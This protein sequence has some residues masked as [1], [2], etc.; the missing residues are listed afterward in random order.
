MPS[1]EIS[2]DEEASPAEVEAVAAVFAEAGFNGP[3]SAN[4]GRRSLGDL[5]YVVYLSATPAVFFKGFLEAAGKDGYESL[6]GLVLKVT[7]ARKGRDGSIV[8]EDRQSREDSTVLVLSA[9]LPD[10]AFVALED[11][12]L[13]AL[14]GTYLVWDREG[15]KG[16]YDPT[17]RLRRFA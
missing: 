15:G 6:K 11:L 13:E 12:D 10:E 17:A 5:P 3:V 8:V 1:F 4:V 7:E 9:D 2:M 14:K 16:W